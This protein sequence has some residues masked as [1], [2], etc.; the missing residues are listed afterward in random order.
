VRQLTVIVAMLAFQAIAFADDSG[1]WDLAYDVQT[2]SRYIP[3]ELWTGG[4]W[5]GT[6]EL[7]MR[8]VSLDFGGHKHISG[9]SPYVR[10]GTST[11]ILVYERT[12]KDKRQLFT[13]SSA[14]D[15]LGRVYDSRFERNCTDEI[16][17]PLG[18][19]QNGETRTFKIE[20]NGGTLHRTIELTV[21]EI[22]FTYLGIRHSLRF[23]WVVD[24]GQGKATDMRYT[25]SPGKGLVYER[26]NE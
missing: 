16:K 10:P 7:K 5:D 11:E 17:M 15:G 20:C 22:D 6:R 14:G 12:N 19:W 8:P 24:G 23:H 25:Y 26:G 9:P 13:L 4:D 21:E 1:P 3:V 18:L 2:K